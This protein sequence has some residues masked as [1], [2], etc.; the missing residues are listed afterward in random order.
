MDNTK[1]ALILGISLVASGLIVAGG[2]RH[3][4][5]PIGRFQM[6]GVPMHAYVIDTQ[7]GKV[8]EQAASPGQAENDKGFKDPKL[9]KP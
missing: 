9:D 1:S 6:M 4:P 7:T 2:L 5:E 8:W 3:H